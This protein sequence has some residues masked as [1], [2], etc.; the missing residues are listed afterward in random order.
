MVSLYPHSIQALSND[1]TLK[2]KTGEHKL[3]IAVILRTFC[4]PFVVIRNDTLENMH[5][6]RSSVW[7]P[8]DSMLPFF[9][10]WTENKS[11]SKTE[12][13]FFFFAF[14]LANNCL[15]T[16]QRQA[17]AAPTHQQHVITLEHNDA[18]PRRLCVH[19]LSLSDH[20]LVPSQR[21]T[22]GSPRLLESR[23]H[24]S[25]SRL[26]AFGSQLLFKACLKFSVFALDWV[27]GIMCRPVLRLQLRRQTNKQ[28]EA[29][30][31]LQLRCLHNATMLRIVPV[32]VVRPVLVGDSTSCQRAL[33]IKYATVPTHTGVRRKKLWYSECDLKSWPP[34]FDKAQSSLSNAQLLFLKLCHCFVLFF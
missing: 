8:E 7:W 17:A 19:V 18:P 3:M 26:T 28:T 2:W 33:V 30:P 22:T 6:R 14:Y 24:S 27:W 11:P 31:R 12:S 13:F 21:C 1:H 20:T 32:T 34:F 4:V 23:N 29:P 16:P 5:R 10:E 25:R 15:W 9:L